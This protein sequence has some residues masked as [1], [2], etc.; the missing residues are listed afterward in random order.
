MAEQF[1]V[2]GRGKFYEETGAIRDVIQNHVLHLTAIL[3]MDAPVGHEIESIRDEKVRLLKAI[4]PLDPKHIVRGQF[5]GYRKEPGV[6][7]DS[8]VETFA[9][10][11]LQIETSRWAGVPFLIR[12][13]KSLATSAFEIRVQFK[14]P[15]REIF[16]QSD[17]PSEYMR[18]RIGPEVTVQAV[19]LRVKHPGEAMVG[20]EV[21]LL[22]SESQAHD[23]L[24]YSR[25]LGDAF[26]GDTNLFSREDLINQ[27]WR[28][29]DPVLNMEACPHL[30]EPGT[31]GPAEANELVADLD[32]GWYAPAP[33]PSPER[34]AA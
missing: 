13:G 4:A 34:K 21:E 11:R 24:P 31:W 29:V 19:G 20:E 5:R 7:K 23:L 6:A 25:L 32:G 14:R 26:H 8:C 18:F 16:P 2:Q 22:A 3:A 15:V 12:A 30:Y 9:A 28:I 27:Q 33:V 17:L 10:A 1:G